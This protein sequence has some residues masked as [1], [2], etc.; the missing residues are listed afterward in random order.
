MWRHGAAAGPGL[1]RQDHP[2]IQAHRQPSC[3]VELEPQPGV[4]RAVHV[5]AHRVLP[6]GDPQDA[7]AGKDERCKAGGILAEE[8]TARVVQQRA[9]ARLAGLG[10]HHS[11]LQLQPDEGPRHVAEAQARIKGHLVERLLPGHL[12]VQLVGLGWEQSPGVEP[13]VQ[14]V[15]LVPD[16]PRA[17]VGGHGGPTQQRGQEYG[18]EYGTAQQGAERARS[19]NAHWTPVQVRHCRAVQEQNISSSRSARGKCSLHV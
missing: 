2:A 11:T 6:G 7:I 14:A 3:G 8:V 15:T 19:E 18:Q 12:G 13:Q 16:I 10:R 9:G 1:A 4:E 17:G 5:V